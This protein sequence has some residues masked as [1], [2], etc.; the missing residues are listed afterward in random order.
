MRPFDRP[1]ARPPACP[2]AVPPVRPASHLPICPP[3]HLPARPLPPVRRPSV[4]RAMAAFVRPLP[5]L[6]SHPSIARCPVVRATAAFVSPL[7]PRDLPTTLLPP[8][9]PPSSSL[10]SPLFFLTLSPTPLPSCPPPSSP[11][12]SFRVCSVRGTPW[13]EAGSS[14]ANLLSKTQT[15]CYLA[16][17]YRP[18]VGLSCSFFLFVPSLPRLPWFYH[19]SGLAVPSWLFS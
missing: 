8:P 18:V 2:S 12:F 16:T 5:H 13:R 11:R 3:A 1:I 14:V 9:L 6:T 19:V 7:L 10:P 15:F 17:C 4:V